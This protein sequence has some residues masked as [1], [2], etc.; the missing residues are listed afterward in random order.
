VRKQTIIMAAVA[1]M[2]ASGGYF[3][4]MILSPEPGQ[5]D[6][7][8]VAEARAINQLEDLLGQFRP[9]F[10][11]G[12]MNGGTV[13]AA[14]FDGKI[15][16]LNF[17]ATWCKPCIE[18]MPM[19]T[20][21]QN[22]YAGRGVQV[23]GI[24][25]D[26]PRKAREFASGVSVNYPILVGSTD[27]I[28]AG[29]RYGNRSGML[30]YSVLVDADGYRKERQEELVERA[31]AVAD[32]VRDGGNSRSLGSLNPFERR[33]VHIALRDDEDVRTLSKGEGFLKRMEIAPKHGGEGNESGGSGR[34]GR[35]RRERY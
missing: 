15:L 22:N 28:L 19:L 9:D 12:D 30:P 27:T 18:E 24:A 14:D 35:R 26:D 11:L 10:E 1:V 16:L 25:L 5:Q 8:P 21:L 2:A 32:E 17:W 20:R 31:H 6:Y 34:G 13:S 7:S 33:L 4:A 29:R 23:V 3:V